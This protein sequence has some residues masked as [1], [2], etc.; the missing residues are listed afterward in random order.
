MSILKNA[1]RAS[2]ADVERAFITAALVDNGW[3]Y[4]KAARDLGVSRQLI[5]VK[6]SEYGITRASAPPEYA[7]PHITSL[8]VGTPT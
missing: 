3:S 2:R 8:Q 1:L 6:V 5:A 4:T 7:T